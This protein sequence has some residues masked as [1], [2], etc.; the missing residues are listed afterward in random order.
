MV[1]RY[2]G[3]LL[4]QK[5]SGLSQGTLAWSEGRFPQHQSC[6]GSERPSLSIL[7]YSDGALEGFTPTAHQCGQ[8]EVKS[9][10]S[11]QILG[12]QGQ[13][14][15]KGFIGWVMGARCGCLGRSQ[16]QIRVWGWGRRD[17]RQPRSVSCKQQVSIS[18]LQAEQFQRTPEP[19]LCPGICILCTLA[20]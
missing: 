2:S 16:E 9:I 14:R 8:S 12:N 4:L 18:S 17:N 5:V 11:V 10:L 15:P 7:S 20:S 3:S 19:R 6:K 13:I 1:T